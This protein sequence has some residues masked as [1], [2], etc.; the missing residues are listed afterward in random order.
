VAQQS[1]AAAARTVAK[2]GTA[3]NRRHDLMFI[4]DSLSVRIVGVLGPHKIV[5][6]SWATLRQEKTEMVRRDNMIFFLS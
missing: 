3:A 2:L 1:A 6:K 5:A 4:A